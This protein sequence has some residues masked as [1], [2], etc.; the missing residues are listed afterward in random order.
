MPW[1]KQES[2][3]RQALSNLNT[4]KRGDQR[5]VHKPLLT[6]MLIAR[7]S[8]GGDR[9]VRFAA[10]TEELTKL[11]KE[12]GPHRTSYHTEFPFW[13]LQTDGFWVVEKKSELSFQQRGLS[14]TKRTL[15]THDAVGTV[16]L[17]L[18]EALRNSPTLQQEL[19]QQLLD[20][21]WPS[22]LHDAI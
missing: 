18:W 14:P 9:R 4:W 19:A 16:P 15:L 5:A 8:T 13:H 6:L 11:L 2:F 17:D 22:T 7:A 12:F 10:I 20:A 21:F 1:E 3:W